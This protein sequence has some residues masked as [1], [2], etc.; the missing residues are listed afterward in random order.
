MTRTRRS[1]GSR[2]FGPYTNVKLLKKALT[3]MRKVFPLRSCNRLPKKLCLL[4]HIDECLG[5]CEGRVSK[6]GYNRIVKELTLFLDGKRKKLLKQLSKGMQEAS[7]KL[8][9]EKVVEHFMK[10]NNCDRDTFEKHEEKAFEH[11]RKRS[12]HEWQVDFGEYGDII[13]VTSKKG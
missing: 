6:G 1:D 8:D 4:Y 12:S 9:Y 2:Y 13:Q 7:R 3:F 5:P 10:V 11:W